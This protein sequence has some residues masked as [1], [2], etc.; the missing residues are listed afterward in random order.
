M[1]NHLTE[2]AENEHTEYGHRQW[3]KLQSCITEVA[4]EI[5]GR[6]KYET[7]QPWITIEILEKMN[8]RS[9]LKQQSHR[10]DEYKNVL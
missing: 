8:E 6:R 1:D 9:K 5:R 7:K 4:E 3:Q 2:H 10:R